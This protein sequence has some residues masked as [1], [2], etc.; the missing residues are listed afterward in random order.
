MLPQT[1]R[2]GGWRSWRRAISF[3]LRW[4][5]RPIGWQR[6]GYFPEGEKLPTTVEE[7]KKGLRLPALFAESATSQMRPMLGMESR[8][9]TSPM[10]GME[11]S[12]RKRLTG[13][14]LIF[15]KEAEPAAEFR[16]LTVSYRSVKGQPK[17]IFHHESEDPA[18]KRLPDWFQRRG[19]IHH[20]EASDRADPALGGGSAVKR[21]GDPGY[22]AGRTSPEASPWSTR[23]RRR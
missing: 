19:E 6:K 3:R 9:E 4:P 13:I 8:P 10:P 5:L 23:T 18:G 20:H 17:M 2:C 15:Q 16:D 22:K 14:C 7:G 11:S 12:K 1:R 21:A